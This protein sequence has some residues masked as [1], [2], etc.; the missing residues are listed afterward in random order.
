MSKFVIFGLLAS[1]VAIG[2]MQEN[3]HSGGENPAKPGVINPTIIAAKINPAIIEFPDSPKQI[4]S[5]E[6]AAKLLAKNT[7]ADNTP[8]NNTPANNASA[9]DAP[10][11]IAATDKSPEK[12]PDKNIDKKIIDPQ[13]TP[14]KSEYEI[15]KTE[16]TDAISKP[17]TKNLPAATKPD[18]LAMLNR[19]IAPPAIDLGNLTKEVIA[20][21]PLNLE[22]L[23]KSD[24]D[25]LGT[26]KFGNSVMASAKTQDDPTGVPK[27]NGSDK[28]DDKS[29]SPDAA[30]SAKQSDPAKAKDEPTPSNGEYKI[31][32]IYDYH[33]FKTDAKKN[34]P[35]RHV[36]LQPGTGNQFTQPGGGVVD[37]EQDKRRI[38]REKTERLLANMLFS[39]DPAFLGEK[40]AGQELAV[41]DIVK[42]NQA[43]DQQITAMRKYWKLAMAMLDY[44]FAVHEF[45]TLQTGVNTVD[46]N[47]RP[48]YI[49]AYEAAQA[50]VLETKSL[51]LA[52]QL[53][54]QVQLNLKA[55]PVPVDIPWVGT[56]RTDFQLVSK[57]FAN[58][59][60]YSR[61]ESIDKTINL[62]RDAVNLR[63][64]VAYNS[65]DNLSTCIQSQRAD[66]QQVVLAYEQLVKHRRAF[67]AAVLEFNYDIVDYV[68]TV[69][70]V[71]PLG[72]LQDILTRRPSKPKQLTATDTA[73]GESLASRQPTVI[74]DGK[75]QP[76]T[77]ANGVDDGWG[78]EQPK[79]NTKSV[80][81][82]SEATSARPQSDI[83]KIGG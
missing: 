47:I 12:N 43:R 13:V 75:V 48:L 76:T 50:R 15:A 3:M 49:A 37:P 26:D 31:N 5:P 34:V 6:S 35:Q 46:I 25:K 40:L 23:E 7:P 22:P 39:Q 10:S 56:Y 16:K 78:S 59:N 62:W 52:A 17:E 81:V 44:R 14:A 66:A 70:A 63:A 73:N 83:I 21:R 58:S 80:L 36:A 27:L 38:A 41:A 20:L 30:A 54:L 51:M 60:Q 77:F 64:E 65:G 29:N 9:S 19:S 18:E 42:R 4:T 53:D 68:F 33:E 24:S 11:A 28:S 71:T 67:I 74:V 45:D 32:S 79:D 57:S 72:P 61:L 82:P 55:L 69:N 8:A 2:G 1:A